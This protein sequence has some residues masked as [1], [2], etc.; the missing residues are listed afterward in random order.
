MPFGSFSLF[1]TYLQYIF[2][3]Q[4]KAQRTLQ[5]LFIFRLIILKNIVKLLNIITQNFRKIY[6]IF[7]MFDIMIF[8]FDTGTC[9]VFQT[10]FNEIWYKLSCCNSD[11]VTISNSNYLYNV[12]DLISNNCFT[13]TK[14]N[15][16]NFFL[17]SNYISDVAKCLS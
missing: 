2:I 15:S 7:L 11:E 14:L 17:I 3:S 6:L 12:S 10:V 16:F 8:M 1:V 4:V 5:F 13:A 9:H